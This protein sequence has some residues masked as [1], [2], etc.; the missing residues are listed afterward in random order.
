MTAQTVTENE[1]YVLTIHIDADY[2]ADEKT[3]YPI[4]IDPTIEISYDNNGEGAIE[5]VT[6]NNAE[7]VS[8]ISGAIS[9]GK[10]GD[11]QSV[12]RMLMKFPNVNFSSMGTITSATVYIRDIMCQHEYLTL[13]C[14]VFN[15]NTW[16]ES[17]SVTWSGVSA[18][19]IGTYLDTHEISYYEG[20]EL[21]D[22]HY[23]DY[24]ITAAAQGW[25]SGTLNSDKGIIFK[26][27]SD[28]ESSTTHNYKTFASYNRANYKPYLVVVSQFW[29]C[30][31]YYEIEIQASEGL[32]PDESLSM[33][34]QGYAFWTHDND[35]TWYSL[36]EFSAIYNLSSTSNE[37]MYGVD[38]EFI[39]YKQLLEDNWLDVRFEGKWEEVYSDN[40]GL[41]VDLDFDQWLVA[42]RVINSAGVLDYHFWY[43]TDT[44]KWANKH[45]NNYSGSELLDELPTDDNSRGWL[46]D[47]NLRYDSDIIYYVMTE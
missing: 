2:L 37:A 4:R 35:Y 21:A 46:S 12:S 22:A 7:T 23:Y 44:G 41:D 33:N 16:S 45:G 5:D 30:K 43:R 40:G 20:I 24:D 10:Y 26:A 29:G 18:D 38:G 19:S 9:A 8:G 1:E 11:D 6:I 15:G 42:F 39:G 47:F 3:L 17:S 13:D 14:Y 27:A 34:C 25:G 36:D 32:E 28:H 31:E